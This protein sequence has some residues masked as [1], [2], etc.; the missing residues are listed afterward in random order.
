MIVALVY[1]ITLFQYST[2]TPPIQKSYERVITVDKIGSGKLECC[3][4]G[5]CACS[6][7]SLAI[8][9]VQDNTE[10]RVI[11]DIK[12]HH[13]VNCGN[14]SNI[15][16]MGYNNPTIMCDYQ[17]G[18]VGDHFDNIIIQNVIWDKCITIYMKCL[19]NTFI[20]DCTFQDFTNASLV[21]DGCG[22]VHI[23]NSSFSH[24]HGVSVYGTSRLGEIILTVN[25]SL[26]HYNE[27]K[28]IAIF[29]SYLITVHI[30][31]CDFFNNTDTAIS[32]E[33]ARLFLQGNVTF[34]N[35]S[36]VNMGTG[37]AAIHF[38][39][40]SANMVARN[41]SA[42]C[43]T[44]ARVHMY[45]GSVVFHNNVADNGGAVYLGYYSSM[46]VNQTILEFIGNTAT[47]FGGAVYFELSD[48]PAHLIF[49]CSD[50][51]R[52]YYNI[53]INAAIFQNNFAIKGGDYGY[54]NIPTTYQCRENEPF[55][56]K[57]LFASPVDKVVFSDEVT[58][59]VNKSDYESGTVLFWSHDL[60]FHILALDYFSNLVAPVNGTLSCERM[61]H[62][63]CNDSYSSSFNYTIDYEPTLISK[64]AM[65]CCQS[66]I[67]PANPFSVRLKVEVA[68][69]ASNLTTATVRWRGYADYCNDFMHHYLDLHDQTL[70]C[71]R[72]SCSVVS[73]GVINIPAPGLT[74]P[75][76]FL[77][78][79]P[80][81]WY[82]DGFRTYVVS[83]PLQYC[84]YNSWISQIPYE[85]FPDGNL[86]CYPHWTG[87]SCGECSYHSGYAINYGTT[88]CVPIQQC[89]TT[90]VASSLAL[91]FSVSFLYWFLVISVIFFLLNLRLSLSI[92]YT[93]GIILY[94]SVIDQVF[95]VY[96]E[97]IQ[98]KTCHV[99]VKLQNH[100]H[101]NYYDCLD[102]PFDVSSA[103]PFFSSIGILKP[104]FLQY[105]K[106]CF[107]GSNLLDHLFIGYIHP[108]VVTIVVIIALIVSRSSRRVTLFVG[109][110]LNSRY[111]CLLLLLSYSSIS[112]TS[113]QLLRLT[114]VLGS[115]I[116]GT[117][118]GI[119]LTW[120][121]YWSPNLTYFAGRHGLYGAVA[122]L[123]VFVIGLGLPLLILL[124]RH[125]AR[126]WN[127][128]FIRLKPILDQLQGCYKTEC[129]WFAA[130]YL[131]CRQMIFVVDITFDIFRG[132]LVEMIVVK[133][134]LLLFILGFILVIH[135]WY[136]PYRKKG[137]NMLDT[138]ILIS[139]IVMTFS[140]LDG[141]SYNIVVV[142][143]ILPILFLLNY[144][145]FYTKLRHVVALL[146]ICLVILLLNVL[147]F[148]RFYYYDILYIVW[149][150]TA[151]LLFVVYVLFLCK[152]FYF[153]V[154]KPD[155]EINDAANCVS[156]RDES[157]DS[158]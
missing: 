142:F 57:R 10:I 154:C 81:Y 58:V 36:C 44:S 46:Y 9:Q 71:V 129:Y 49:P 24:N 43:L 38:N 89:L 13:N 115:D 62:D 54:F 51:I 116:S 32:L 85:P 48:S 119:V 70:H 112:Y 152:R 5:K 136:Q 78:A 34:Y 2:Q 86:Q 29:G 28:S 79:A 94:Y 65:A 130:F 157:D 45:E 27:E 7:L 91:L 30:T 98:T 155:L 52:D 61:H 6:N 99:P 100:Y 74:C 19:R 60:H 127:I 126:Y 22:S 118:F 121:A 144:F 23:D 122:L 104:P 63:T 83:C 131:L 106:L 42:I 41:G 139:L 124:P 150:V 132:V 33:T 18:L 90:S 148:S 138:A 135:M 88:D 87:F 55:D 4:D 31:T 105:M 147:S 114:A 69:V 93:L 125:L 111:I 128:N 50:L 102:A 151:C 109:R 8:E 133:L 12:L 72:L 156:D 101:P 82:D 120:T 143:W 15:T 158:D 11:S 47:S 14:V 67:D 56:Q 117:Q 73:Q 146:S 25:G 3:V 75:N 26:F 17:G 113:I 1:L 140:S 76:G 96:K 64:D 53:L 20:T 37:S 92:E 97:V 16:I 149:M 59:W 40:N 107:P 95:S 137:L 134:I 108:I 141:K 21:L 153:G 35:N 103:L 123:C 84:D 39:N 80:G 66:V 145:T 110:Y 68:G 77:V